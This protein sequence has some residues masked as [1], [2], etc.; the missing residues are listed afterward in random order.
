MIAAILGSCNRQSINVMDVHEI[1]S[2]LLEGKY[3]APGLFPKIEQLSTIKVVF[4]LDFGLKDIPTEPG[5]ILIRGGRQLGKST[6]LEQK[7]KDS[8]RSFGPGSTFYLN[9][10]E[11]IAS[12]GLFESIR[13]LSNQFAKES[14]VKRIFIDEITAINNWEKAIKRLAD[15][16]ITRDVLIVTTGSKTI[17]L[18]RGTERLPGRKGKLART[19][20]R[21]TPLSFGEFADK[22]RSYFSDSKLLTAY[23]LTGGSPVAI[24][25]LI[26]NGRIPDYVIELTRDWIFGETTLQGRSIDCMKRV[27]AILIDRGGLP[28]SLHTLAEEAGLAN[29]TVAQGYVDI[30]KDL[31]CLSSAMRMDSNKF[32]PLAR[33]ASKYHFTY[34]L[35][36]T[37]L[38]KMKPRTLADFDSL[39]GQEKGKWYEW[40][41]AQ[42]LW[43]KASI[44]GEDMPEQQYFWKTDEHE[45]DFIVDDNF[46]EVKS[47]H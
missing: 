32:R 43:R 26:E 3:E 31:G 40:L 21:F 33:K 46:Y 4:E 42:E 18:R 29:N 38:S 5:L 12:D 34:L 8:A 25:G 36:A 35:T 14:K 19:N 7:L 47:G 22:T 27:I 23:L 20:Y 45:V 6:W 10:D 1:N 9:G 41:V 37:A 24:N 28:L 44:A 17:D 11:I 13:K 30:L 39:P 15:Q 16:G 2:L